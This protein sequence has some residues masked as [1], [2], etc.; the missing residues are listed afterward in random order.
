MLE[1][2]PACLG[3]GDFSYRL[4]VY[5]PL[6]HLNDGYDELVEKAIGQQSESSGAMM[7]GQ[8]DIQFGFQSPADREKAAQQVANL[9]MQFAV[10]NVPQI[11]SKHPRLIKTPWFSHGNAVILRVVQ[12]GSSLEPQIFISSHFPT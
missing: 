12:V 10:G 6:K 3:S 1:H 7:G 4:D 9:G 11:S 8:R 2:C 5:Y